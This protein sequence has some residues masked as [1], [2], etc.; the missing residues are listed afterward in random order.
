MQFHGNGVCSL[1]KLAGSQSIIKND[2]LGFRVGR[3]KIGV[4]D[5]GVC[6]VI[7]VDFTAIQVND[8]GVITDDVK[9]QFGD[10]DGVGDLKI[11]PE[12]DSGIGSAKGANV[13]NGVGRGNAG[14]RVSQPSS[15]WSLCSIW[16]D[17]GIR[18]PSVVIKGRVF[19]VICAIRGGF[20]HNIARG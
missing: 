16:V 13:Q 19:P 4:V 3:A 11:L 5:H 2:G 15:K 1:L 8:H 6:K 18:C 10:I 9:N 7:A 17:C 20:N 14:D 12:V